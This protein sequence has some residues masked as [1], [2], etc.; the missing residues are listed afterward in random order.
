MLINFTDLDKLFHKII[1]QELD[2][3]RLDIEIPFFQTSIPTLENIIRYLW[4]RL[5]PEI[6]PLGLQLQQITLYETPTPYAHYHRAL[7]PMMTLTQRYTF[8][9]AHRLWNPDWPDERN[10]QC[11][12]P[13]ARLHGHNYAVEVTLMGMPHPE[14]GM[15]MSL[16]ELD[17]IVQT[18]LLQVVDHYYLD[19]DVDFLA[20][21]LSTTEN[22]A[23][24]FF[25][26]L[27]PHILPPVTLHR[28]RLF[29]SDQNWIDVSR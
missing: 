23:E 15:I 22:L 5:T 18:R 29:E 21:M 26:R 27:S 9:A 10:H 20:G 16:P 7:A 12:G 19:T 17:H 6:I 2:H 4:D 14:T 24:A 11:F 28:L 1:L 25:N 13:C 3:R 8:A